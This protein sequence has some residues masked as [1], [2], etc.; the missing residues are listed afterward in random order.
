MVNSNSFSKDESKTD[1]LS[2]CVEKTYEQ[3]ITKAKLEKDPSRLLNIITNLG[4]MVKK[5]EEEIKKMEL[6][7]CAY[8]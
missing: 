2:V 6:L 4:E 3:E 7:L 8:Q 1:S 5:R